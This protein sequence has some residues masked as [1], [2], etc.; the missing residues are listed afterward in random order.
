MASCKGRRKSPQKCCS[1]ATQHSYT[2][3]CVKFC[4]R[5]CFLG[6]VQDCSPVQVLRPESERHLS[7]N[8]NSWIFCKL[9]VP[10]CLLLEICIR[11]PSIFGNSRIA[12]SR[13]SAKLQINSA[14]SSGAVAP[15]FVFW[16]GAPGCWP[17]ASSFL[18]ANIFT[19]THICISRH[20]CVY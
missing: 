17:H 18:A 7:M 19:Y 11:A 6:V 20:M 2:E 12:S 8:L 3:R 14:K 16:A 4:Y 1:S 13:C 9:G 10:F 15:C 5:C